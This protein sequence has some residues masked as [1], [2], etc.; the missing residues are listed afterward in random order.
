MANFPPVVFE[1]QVRFD[2][3]D[4]QG[5]VFFGTF[6]TYMDETFNAYCREIG[7]PY[8]TFDG[9]TTHVAHAELDY[10]GQATFEDILENGMRIESIGDASITAEYAARHQRD[11]EPIASGKVVHVAVNNNSDDVVRVPDP[12]RDAVTAH[13]NTRP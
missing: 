7:L 4:L 6:F 13:Q 3:T 8:S 9:W 11:D 10:H 12:F 2:E 1:N 5:V